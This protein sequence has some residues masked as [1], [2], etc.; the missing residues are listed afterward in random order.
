[1]NKPAHLTTFAAVLLFGFVLPAHAENKQITAD[2]GFAG[3]TQC[4][5]GKKMAG[6][7][8]GASR[9]ITWFSS[10]Q[11]ALRIKDLSWPDSQ[12]T[13]SFDARKS[14]KTQLLHVQKIMHDLDCDTQD[15]AAQSTGLQEGTQNAIQNGTSMDSSVQPH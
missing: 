3:K 2:M 11:V 15:K 12:N 7:R 5:Q 8:E 6:F 14:Q 4:L 1:M 10:N 9:N 13:M